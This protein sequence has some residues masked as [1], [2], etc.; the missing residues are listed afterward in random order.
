MRSPDAPP[1]VFGSVTSDAVEIFFNE[2]A[3]AVKEYPALAALFGN[4]ASTLGSPAA[5]GGAAAARPSQPAAGGVP[6]VAG[7]AT[8]STTDQLI[9]DAAKDIEDYQRLTSEGKLGEAG[10]RLESLKQKLQD[11]QNRR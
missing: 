5:A 3:T 8:P 6:P 9:R 1:F 2:A 7:S 11:L 10:Q 4:A